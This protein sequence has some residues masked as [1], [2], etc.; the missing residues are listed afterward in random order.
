MFNFFD[1]INEKLIENIRSG[2]SSFGVSPAVSVTGS[3]VEV[4]E[5]KTKNAMYAA[6]F[7]GKVLNFD[8]S[9]S[10][11]KGYDDMPIMDSVTVDATGI[12]A[13]NVTASYKMRYPKLQVI[14]VDTS[15]E[16]FSI[17]V[18]AEAACFIPE[19]VKYPFVF[20]LPVLLGGTS[21]NTNTALDSE[22]YFKYTIGFDYTFKNGLYFNTQF[23]HGFFTER[24]YYDEKPQDYIISRIEKKFFDDK[25]KL[26]LNGSLEIYNLNKAESF[27]DIKENIGFQIVKFKEVDEYVFNEFS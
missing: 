24:G 4:P 13:G 21:V 9:L 3:S 23:V 5:T 16:I 11:F 7:S 25:L 26:G 6:K 10:Y 27:S 22:P 1:L 12:L 20:K 2:I 18:W 17:G 14:G 15:G 19:E 8:F